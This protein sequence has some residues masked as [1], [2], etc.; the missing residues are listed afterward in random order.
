MSILQYKVSATVIDSIVFVF[1]LFVFMLVLLSLSCYR[2]SVNKDLYIIIRV[3]SWEYRGIL[4]RRYFVPHRSGVV[5]GDGVGGCR[6]RRWQHLASPRLA[7]ARVHIVLQSG[8][9]LRQLNI[10]FG[11]AWPAL[12]CGSGRGPTDPAW[13]NERHSP[14]PGHLP[15]TGNQRRGHLPLSVIISNPNGNSLIKN[16]LIGKF[17]YLRLVL[18]EGQTSRPYRNI[19][20]HLV[21]ISASDAILPIFA[22]Y[23]IYSTIKWTLATIQRAFERTRLDNKK[24][25]VYAC[26]FSCMVQM[27][28]RWTQ[29]IDIHCGL[30]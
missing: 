30:Q 20:R 23:S 25:K 7:S 2:F 28:A 18:L 27:F 15:P 17:S 16:R 11:S 19:G 9:W 13:T 21:L 12:N 4:R 22:K 29:L 10:R 24:T 5:L 8:R 14:P 3:I 1:A 6:S 26:L